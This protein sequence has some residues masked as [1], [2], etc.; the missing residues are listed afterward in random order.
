[1]SYPLPSQA[2]RKELYAK[3]VCVVHVYVNLPGKGKG[4]VFV[5]MIFLF[6]IS[7]RV[8]LPATNDTAVYVLADIKKC[9]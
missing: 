4:P 9:L 8:H 5:S 3:K 7:A 2:T 6:I 1:M